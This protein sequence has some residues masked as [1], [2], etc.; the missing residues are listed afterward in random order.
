MIEILEDRETGVLH[1]TF[2][3]VKARR[4]LMRIL[5]DSCMH[6]DRA[7]S[8]MAASLEDLILEVRRGKFDMSQFPENPALEPDRK[9]DLYLVEEE[10]NEGV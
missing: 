7:A 4:Y 3:T 2:H 5:D 1:L 8:W 10:P 6:S 9:D